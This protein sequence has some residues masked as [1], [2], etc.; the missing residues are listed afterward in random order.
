MKRIFTAVAIIVFTLIVNQSSAQNAWRLG[1]AGNAGIATNKVYGLVLGADVRL[2]TKFDERNLFILTS[3]LTH[4]FD[5]QKTIDGFTYVP[6]K[7]GFKTFF[8]PKL[9]VAAE[10]G[11]GF[12]LNKGSDASFLWS[13]SFGYS[14]K[15]LDVSIKYEDFTEVKYLQQ[16]ALRIAYGFNL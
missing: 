7:A 12:G 6:L 3:G 4:F 10:A 13:P 1:I 15:K 8:V 5:T 2:Q 9:Y 14:G 16:V 11:V